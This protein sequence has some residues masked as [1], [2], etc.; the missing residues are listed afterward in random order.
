MQGAESRTGRV[1][2]VV[3]CVA[4]ASALPGVAGDYTL[5]DVQALLHH[6]AVNGD[7]AIFEVFTREYWG[8]PLGG[9]RWS[10]S[11]R[12][13]T[14]LGF[15]I[16]HRI[17]SAP[18][19]HHLVGIACW[20]GLCAQVT[21][22][23]RRWLAPN[24]ALVAG[25]LFTVLPIHVENVAS[26]VG[27][28]DVLAAMFSLAAIHFAVPS[29]RAPTWREALL[30]GACFLAA[31]ACKESAALLPLCIEWIAWTSGKHDP[32]RSRVA[33]IRR[34]GVLV[35]VGLAYIV[36]R[37]RMLSVGLPDT[38][39]AAD[40][41]LVMR[42]G[43][44]RT[45]GNF[46]VMGHYLERIVVP[47]RLCSDH[48]YADIIPPRSFFE[49]DALWSW[50]GLALVVVLVRDGV[51]ALRGR[52]PGLGFAALLAFVLV[53]QWVLDLSVIMAERLA[54]WPSVWLVLAF[55]HAL[56]PGFAQRSPSRTRMLV[57]VA[58]GLLALRGIQR[59]LDWR[60]D[61]ALQRSSLEVCPRA[62]HSRFILANALRERGEVD[63]SI[64]HYAVA[65]AGR[66]AFPERFDSPLFDAEDE[67]T[68]A[69]RLP[70]I[71]ELVGAGDPLAYWAAFHAYLVR[72]HAI[73]EAERVR[74]IAGQV[75]R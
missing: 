60:D 6:P 70:R 10:S 37:Q 58:L 27:R 22:L 29:R 39:V 55:V 75:Q 31:L 61:I 7:A 53:G 66:A 4:A 59:T 45:W 47:L 62:V 65:G 69:E 43:P 12:P 49:H 18:W 13:L 5:D 44:W 34:T 73:A 19:L 25:L 28:A 42:E 52:S 50:M 33:F 40:N 23:A 36:W 71:P 8:N 68:L 46:A 48:T 57:G 32:A 35:I 54:L 15:A 3:A 64:W 1:A 20:A 14:T 11:Y 9:E 63:E 16:E 30:A 74:E 21:V 26:I 17:T 67:L 2:L 38:F 56:A 41:L 51:L 72:E 24:A